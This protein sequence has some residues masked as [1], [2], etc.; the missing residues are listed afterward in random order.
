[1][2][3]YHLLVLLFLTSNIALGQVDQNTEIEPIDINQEALNE[4]NELNDLLNL[5]EQQKAQVYEIIY[6]ILIKNEQVHS[7]KLIE[8]DKKAIIKQNGEAKIHMIMDVLV[9]KQKGLYE[10]HVSPLVIPD[11]PVH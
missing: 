2:K 4:S 11:T 5:S 3:I 8:E 9:G 7:M 6:G 1:M 10:S